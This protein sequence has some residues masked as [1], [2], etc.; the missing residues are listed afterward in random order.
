MNPFSPK[1]SADK[2]DNNNA[3]KATVSAREEAILTN[4]LNNITR[5]R[6]VIMR[7]IAGAAP[8]LRENLY[9]INFGIKMMCERF[10]GHSTEC[11]KTAEFKKLARTVFGFIQKQTTGRKIFLVNLSSPILGPNTVYFCHYLT[12]KTVRPE[13]IK[14][15]VP[16]L[17]DFLKDEPAEIEI[18]N[19]VCYISVTQFGDTNF[20]TISDTGTF[21]SFYQVEKKEKMGNEPIFQIQPIFGQAEDYLQVRYPRTSVQF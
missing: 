8:E 3:N 6:H 14:F 11:F 18:D 12:A 7:H 19:E 4:C 5:D 17:E 1:R 2:A 16:A 13:D 21:G 10:D 9:T 20:V 15:M